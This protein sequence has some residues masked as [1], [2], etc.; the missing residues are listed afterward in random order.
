MPREV[1]R[2][3]SSF[4][5]ARRRLSALLTAGCESPSLSA[6]VD[7]LRSS[8]SWLNTTSR[9]RSMS[10]RSMGGWSYS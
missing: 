3:S 4:N 10:R 6:A 8:S 5:T 2:N 7:T 1:R 9:F